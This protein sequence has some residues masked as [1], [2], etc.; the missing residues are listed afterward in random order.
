[1]EIAADAMAA[2]LSYHGKS[3]AFRML[4][5]RRTDGAQMYPGFDLRDAYPHAFV[6]H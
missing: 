5:D 4:L 6:C 1:M 3:G 2:E